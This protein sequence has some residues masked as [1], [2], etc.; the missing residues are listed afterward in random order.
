M[1]REQLERLSKD[2]LQQLILQQQA[3]IEQLQA[4][5]AE[6]EAAIRRRTR[7][8]KDASNSSV[9][10]SQTRK[11]NRPERKPQQKRGPKPGHQGRSRR[12]QTPDIIV[13]CRPTCCDRC[14]AELPPAGGRLLGAGQVVELPPV[15]PVV[16]EARRYECACPAC[17]YRQAA[18]YPL[19]LEPQRVFGPRLEALVCY[20]HHVV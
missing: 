14:G 12:R 1:S 17:G 16:I 7:P 10:P 20:F 9:P 18:D 13:E 8:P 15:R 4:R 11:P 3:L 2:E 19:G 6:L 5:V